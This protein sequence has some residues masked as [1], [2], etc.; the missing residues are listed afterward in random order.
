MPAA[1]VAQLGAREL[2]RDDGVHEPLL[3]AVVQVA[4]WFDVAGAMTAVLGRTVTPHP[5]TG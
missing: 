5:T 1:R 3:G 2:G 4:T